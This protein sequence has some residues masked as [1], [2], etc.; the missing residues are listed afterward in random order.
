MITLESALK[1]LKKYGYNS[2]TVHPYLYKKN[3][4]IGIN[5][6]Y[7]D[8]KYGITERVASFYSDLELDKFLKRFQWYKLNGKKENVSMRLNNYEISN[9]QVLY[10][11][12]NHVMTDEE[13]FDIKS[14]EKKE[15]K[16]KKLSHSKRLFVE[17]QRLMDRY[18]LEK[19]YLEKYTN[20]LFNK[21]RE[22]TRY[23]LELQKLV[24]K[25]NRVKRD[26]IIDNDNRSFKTDL[27][28]ESLIN[29]L[30]SEYK[31]KM[32]SEDRLNEL[33]VKVW[34]LNK[35]L[36]SNKDYMF[37]LKTN[38][39]ID[40][41]MRLAVTKIDFM[42]ELLSKRKIK[43]INLS[44]KF[45]SIDKQ[46]TYESIYD[47]NFDEKYLDFIEKKY[48]VLDKINEFR[49]CEYLNNFKTQKAY[50]IEKN[51]IRCSNEV[52]KKDNYISIDEVNKHLK[53][54]FDNLTNKEK[55]ALILFTSFYEKLFIMIQN[56]KNYNSISTN[57]LL[58]ILN[59]NKEFEKVFR[60]CYDNIKYLI[61]L[62]V[63]K[64]I[65]NDIFKNIDFTNK[66]SFIES[67][68][69]QLDIIININDKIKLNDNIKLYFSTTDFDN[70]GTFNF[71]KTSSFIAPYMYN[72]NNKNYRVI[73]AHVKKGVYVLYCP[74]KLT[75]SKNSIE[76]LDIENTEIYIDTRD[77]SFNKENNVVLY[78]RFKKNI[79][80]S[81]KYS[82][83][84]SFDVDYKISINKVIIEKRLEN[85]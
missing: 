22:L 7:I 38:D 34:I 21:E 50:D 65:K 37:A 66:I 83:V 33:I 61:E 31:K 73:N 14:F 3:N 81:K 42:K 43:L 68:K 35:E 49:L 77:I 27:K 52:N 11:R 8:D 75:L 30:I 80:N 5:Y 6:S 23:Y 62:D 48:D 16:N 26:L 36:D 56:F 1:I 12:N 54:Q 64:K 79:I 71:I 17:I 82:Y 67:I 74:I 28:L 55:N 41:E 57:K 69:N 13:L 29:S 39:D 32:P 60:D 63:N 9:P 40:E 4:E 72:S 18:Y 51:I 53:K 84:N 20:N 47:D 58:N 76:L 15:N 85:E 10:I 78:S 25:Y 70:L 19:D 46:S 45:D 44:K 59:N 2:M 24:D